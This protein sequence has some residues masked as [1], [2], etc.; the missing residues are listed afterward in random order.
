MPT[1]LRGLPTASMADL[2][3][4]GSLWRTI[5]TRRSAGAG[6]RVAKFEN[7]PSTVAE[8]GSLGS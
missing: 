3:A 6:Q 2:K 7:W 5:C 1:I 4:V 8:R